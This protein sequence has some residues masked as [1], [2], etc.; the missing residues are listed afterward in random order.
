MAIICQNESE[1][2]LAHINVSFDSNIGCC[3]WFW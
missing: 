2:I 1:G 3:L